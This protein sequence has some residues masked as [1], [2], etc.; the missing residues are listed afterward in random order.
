MIKT[1]KK[2]EYICDAVS[3]NEAYSRWCARSAESDAPDKYLRIVDLREILREIIEEDLSLAQRAAVEMHW[4]EGLTV[5][6]MAK[7]LGIS[8]SCTY[9]TLDRAMERIREGMKHLSGC[10]VCP[11]TQN[12]NERMFI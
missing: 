2:C 3:Q 9:K 12:E 6:D 10:P 5:D 4:Y 11:D 8:R 1:K 7:R